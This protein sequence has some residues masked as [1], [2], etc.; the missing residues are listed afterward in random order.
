MA[1]VP[2][3][4]YGSIVECFTKPFA[5]DTLP[6]PNSGYI[7]AYDSTYRR[8]EATKVFKQLLTTKYGHA[9]DFILTGE[10]IDSNGYIKPSFVTKYNNLDSAGNANPRRLANIE[11]RITP[12]TYTNAY[13]EI[14]NSVFVTLVKRESPHYEYPWNYEYRIPPY[15]VVDRFEF[16]PKQIQNLKFL[17]SKLSGTAIN[18]DSS[19]TV[20]GGPVVKVT[21]VNQNQIVFSN[22]NVTTARANVSG[23]PV[24]QLTARTGTSSGTTPRGSTNTGYSP[25][26]GGDLP[27]AT[28]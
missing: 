1:I 7:T 16:N 23:L 4:S 14:Q 11:S 6:V 27:V 21:K 24:R 10:D 15:S 2:F 28:D 5:G 22:N 8:K 12:T 25:A 18:I 3:N 20:D 19:Q 26:G 13:V 9:Y 17:G